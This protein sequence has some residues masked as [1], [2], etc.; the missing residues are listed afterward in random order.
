MRIV[1]VQ[2]GL[3]AGGA[4]KVVNLLAHHRARLGDEVHVLSLTGR[5]GGSYFAYDASVQVRSMVPEGQSGSSMQ[6]LVKSVRWLRRELLGLQPAVV[7]SFLTKVNVMAV[8]AGLGSGIPI[9]I[10]ERNNPT[11]QDAHPLWLPLSSLAASLSARLVMQ[12]EGA[13]NTL[14]HRL[15]AK[16]RVIGN[17]SHLPLG[18]RTRAAAGKR[19]VAVGRLEVQKGFDLLLN[20]FAT[21]AARHPAATLTVFGEGAERGNLESRVA[22]LGISSKVRFAGVTASPGTWIGEAD[23]FVLSSRYEGFPNVLLEALG[24]GLPVVAFD[25][26]WGPASMV[27][28]EAT[29]LL[30]PAEDTDAL[31]AALDRVLSD[32]ELRRKLARAAPA[33]AQPFSPE[34]IMQAWDDLIVE[35]ARSSEVGKR[36]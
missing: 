11:R 3:G 31:A 9:I 20:G 10:S 12:T 28:N 17:P 15:R 33:A 19:I 1:L 8:L 6:R 21:I 26:P 22:S 23:V 7:V 35:V 32:T 36:A 18:A 16:S 29:G 13:R 4:E 24:A 14:P 5:T 30:V 34:N 27:T 2:A 25:C